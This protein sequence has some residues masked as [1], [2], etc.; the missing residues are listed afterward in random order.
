LY[1]LAHNDIIKGN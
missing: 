1:L